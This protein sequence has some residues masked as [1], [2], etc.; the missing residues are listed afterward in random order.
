MMFNIS[1]ISISCIKCICLQEKNYKLHTQKSNPFYA[2]P[3]LEEVG[4]FVY[5][6]K[7]IDLKTD[8]FS[9]QNARIRSVK[10][11]VSEFFRNIFDTD[12]I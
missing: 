10:W 12:L 2:L 11:S 7:S 9:A 6:A 4:A 1:F 8:R 3:V 5:T